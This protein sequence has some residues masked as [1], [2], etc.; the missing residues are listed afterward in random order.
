MLLIG[1][2]YLL[3]HQHFL[4]QVKNK[5][6]CTIHEYLKGETLAELIKHLEA[7]GVKLKEDQEI[8]YINETF[9]HIDPNESFYYY[10]G[11]MD[12]KTRP[13]CEF[14]LQQD[15]LYSQED[16]DRLSALLGYDVFLYVAGFNCRHKWSRARIKTHIQDGYHPD[17]PSD[18]DMNKA[19][20]KQPTSVQDYF[21][22]H[23]KRKRSK[24]KITKWSEILD[25]CLNTLRSKKTK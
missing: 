9:D 19:A 25:Q 17:Q 16:I 6:M 7:S 18:R 20:V 22:K 1:K 21:K 15:K 12:D 3:N 11:P 4:I 14:M 13:F 10:Q 23:M 24:G 2:H 5:T 8:E